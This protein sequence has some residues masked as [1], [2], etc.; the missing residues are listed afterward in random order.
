V[1]PEI[2]I[3]ELDQV[4][5]GHGLSQVGHL[6]LLEVQE[7]LSKQ[8]NHLL[9]WQR[10]GYAADMGYMK[11][12]VELFTNPLKLFPDLQSVV[13]FFVPYHQPEVVKEKL[14]KGPAPVGFG[15]IARYAWGRDY[16][17][18]LKARLNA[19]I[20][21]LSD[22]FSLKEQI[23]FR[24]FSDAVPL[25]E[26]AIGSHI[27]QAFVGK[28]TMLINPS[29]GS[30]FFIA[31]ILWNIKITPSRLSLLNNNLNIK[32]SHCGSC[33]RCKDKCPTNAFVSSYNLDSRRCISYLTIEKRGVLSKWE[34]NAIGDWLFG[35]DI[36]QEVCPFNHP[37][38]GV[39][40]LEEFDSVNGAGNYL[41]LENVLDIADSRTFNDLFAGSALQRTGRVGL[42]RNACCVVANRRNY[43][44]LDRL[45]YLAIED[46]SNI[47][48][49]QALQSLVQMLDDSSGMDR[50]KILQTID[51]LEL[52]KD[53]Y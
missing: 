44:L 1:T 39:E 29:I 36:C 2:S 14:S 40:V 13:C 24:I 15:K 28:N 32:K 19:L 6:S 52:S 16:H 43:E 31:E 22:K 41:K 42:V 8:S 23:S 48:Q 5:Q 34:S 25:L 53:I 20:A 18:V 21:E 37:R 35:C 50:Q 38:V 17:L 30:Y 49:Q 46:E 12:D 26:R 11:R 9:Q 45:I 27:G 4:F 47:V 33:Q 7:L 10:N 3:D 51:K